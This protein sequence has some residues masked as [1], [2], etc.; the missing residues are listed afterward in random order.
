MAVGVEGEKGVTM[1]IGHIGL[2]LQRDLIPLSQRDQFGQG[3]DSGRGVKWSRFR[4]SSAICAGLFIRPTP[5]GGI[6]HL[7]GYGY[8]LRLLG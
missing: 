2:W 1:H 4:S 5:R 8:V 7:A 6:A 3:L